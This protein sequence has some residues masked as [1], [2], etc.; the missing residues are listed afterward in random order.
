MR[1]SDDHC[2][3]ALADDVRRRSLQ[4]RAGRKDEEED[5]EEDKEKE[6]N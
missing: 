5:K 6:E 1:S 3:Q 4:S 2:D